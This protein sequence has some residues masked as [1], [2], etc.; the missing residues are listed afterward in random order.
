MKKI[1]ILVLFLLSA[2]FFS[3]CSGDDIKGVKDDFMRE[4]GTV[5]MCFS[6]MTGETRAK[7]Y[8]TGTTPSE[9]NER[10]IKS[11]LVLAFDDN[12]GQPNVL[13]DIFTNDDIR[14]SN[15]SNPLDG[16]FYIKMKEAGS[17][18]LEVIANVDKSFVSKLSK[19]TMKYED[20]KKLELDKNPVPNHGD[21][22]FVM[23]SKQATRVTLTTVAGSKSLTS[24]DLTGTPIKMVRLAVRFDLY[25][26]V[27]GLDIEKVT[28]KNQITK[29][30]LFTQSSAPDAK[31]DKE[32]TSSAGS[33]F[34]GKNSIVAGI[35]SYENPKEGEVS[36]SL[37]GQLNGSGWTKE[38]KLKDPTDTQELSI[39]RNHLYRI[40]LSPNEHKKEDP[41]VQIEVLDWN[42]GYV[43]EY[44]DDEF[45]ELGVL[46]ADN[47]PLSL[48]ASK[49]IADEAGTKFTDTPY[50][51]GY[52]FSYSDAVSK[53]KDGVT[54][55]GVTYHLP[56][57]EEWMAI[58]PTYSG[59][60]YPQFSSSFSKMDQTEKVKIGNQEIDCKQDL[61][62]SD[63]KVCYA[64]RFKGTDYE[65]AWKYEWTT[66]GGKN[67]LKITSVGIGKN[68][69]K[70][71]DDIMKPDFW[72]TIKSAVE[73]RFLPA[74]G[75][76]SGSGSS[77][78]NNE[79][80]GGRYWS[81][82]AKG[83]SNA[84]YLRFNSSYA[85][86]SDDSQSYGFSVRL[87]APGIHLWL[88]WLN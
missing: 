5:A 79:G 13:K 64:L 61:K 56:S 47:T 23:T 2:I 66:D 26:K 33:W 58:V 76:R 74:A 84:W 50:D 30:Y 22:N 72:T 51:Y 63:G 27:D 60:F 16:N 10:A 24:V 8:N 37:S 38:I 82:S 34:K 17:Y 31:I 48:V 28:L 46:A 75:D 87:F 88:Q 65:S 29:S 25:N 71:I 70:T 54:I 39:K 11:L 19:G 43:F 9:A 57:K 86:V 41:K 49:N 35:Y 81:S 59:G 68:S 14:Y 85:P 53:F 78:S 1:R 12:G 15:P 6:G 18:H 21:E 40:T 67:G 36:L 32:F 42:A 55:E 20:F 7:Q 73:G 45:N 3:S 80:S 77:A 44:D 69:G 4:S 62:C 52:Y 83:S